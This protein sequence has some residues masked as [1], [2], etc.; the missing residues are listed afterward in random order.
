[1]QFTTHW[2]YQS[3]FP[4]CREPVSTALPRCVWVD[5]VPFL[6]S[7]HSFCLSPACWTDLKL[8][9]SVSSLRNY[10]SSSCH[11]HFLQYP[12]AL[13]GLCDNA[14]A[15]ICISTSSSVR[16]ET[17]RKIDPTSRVTRPKKKKKLR[18]VPVLSFASRFFL[19]SEPWPVTAQ[20]NE[21]PSSIWNRV[22]CIL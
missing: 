5:S 1:M 10:Q 4:A 14:G 22:T 13:K 21:V 6:K 3:E 12:V 16:H 19:E 8:S 2:L 15:C 18:F 11:L 17:R 9:Y 20:D 7:F